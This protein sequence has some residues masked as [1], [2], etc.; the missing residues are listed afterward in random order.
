MFVFE[1]QLSRS[2]GHVM[3]TKIYTGIVKSGTVHCCFPDLG[4]RVLHS[5]SEIKRWGETIQPGWHWNENNRPYQSPIYI[6]PRS[7]FPDSRRLSLAG[8]EA[9]SS[10]TA[11][12]WQLGAQGAWRVELGVYPADLEPLLRQ[13]AKLA[14]MCPKT[15]REENSYTQNNRNASTLELA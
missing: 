10:G 2:H 11:L 8:S 9:A 5:S 12:L 13:K 14:I 1:N 7:P 4:P 3:A 15:L 6:F